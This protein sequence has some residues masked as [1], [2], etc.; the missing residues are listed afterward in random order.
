MPI[1]VVT[2]PEAI[3]GLF[4]TWD[5]CRA[6]VAGHPGAR[7]QK[8]ASREEAEAMLSGEGVVLSPGLYGFTDGNHLGGVGVVVVRIPL[9]V[10]ADPDVQE[11]LATSVAGVLAGAAIPGLDSDRSVAEELSRLRNILAELAGLYAAIT[12]LPRDSEATIV[13]DY[14]GVGAWMEGRWKMKDPTVTAVISASRALASSK[15]LQLRFLHQRG[16]M[17]TWAGRHDLARFNGRA[18]E[19]AT[20]GASGS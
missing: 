9:D 19:L 14:K 13:Y 20:R 7:Y 11:E 2:Q 1:Y 12:L 17:S 8:V 18:D 10:A 3:R 4:E 16:H 15:G 5:A 6:A